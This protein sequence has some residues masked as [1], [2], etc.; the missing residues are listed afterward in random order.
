MN[1]LTRVT[2]DKPTAIHHHLTDSYAWHQAFW[3]SFPGRD[4]QERRFLSRVDY[5]GRHYQA[6]LLSEEKPEALDWGAWATKGIAP[7]FLER[8][9]YHFALRA[10]PTIKRVVRDEEGDRKKNGRRVAIY[11]REMLKEWLDRKAQEG[12]FEVMQVDIGPPI[13][14]SFLRKNANGKHISVDYRGVLRVLDRATF[15]ETFRTG[16]G[17]AKAFGF[18]L[19]M[20]QPLS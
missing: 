16:I 13:S 7:A 12:G 8:S 18:G 9:L 20:L 15:K 14:C 1:Y 2:V 3:K 17:P 4:G 11:D 5:Q 19:M 6:L 10:N